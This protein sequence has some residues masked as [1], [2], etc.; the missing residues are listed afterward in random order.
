[1]TQNASARPK[2]TTNAE[3]CEELARRLK[4]N[5]SHPAKAIAKQHEKSKL[6]VPERL[7]L[8]FD[9]KSWR[10]EI[11]A[12][13]ADDM[14]E[15]HG[16][17]ITAAGCRVVI[18]LVHGRPTM[19]IANDSM[20]KAGAWFPMTIRKMLR[21]Q[22]IAIENRLPTVYLVDSA[23]V[24]LPLQEEIF[25]DKEHAGRIFYN[26]SRMSAMGI[27]QVALVCGPCVAGGA[28]L[29]VLSDEIIMVKGTSNMFLA[30][31]YLVEAAIGERVDAETLGGAAMHGQHSG[32]ADFEEDT[33]QLAI[34]RVREIA[35][36]WPRASAGLTREEPAAPKR[37]VEDA[38]T[39]L[40]AMRQMAYDM[41]KLL[42]CIVDEGSFAEFKRNYGRS[43]LCGIARIDGWAVGIVANQ[44]ELVRSGGGEIQIG[45]VI[46]SDSADKAARFILNCNQKGI[47]IIYLQ[48]V[49]G[50]MVGSRAERGGII[51]DGAKLVNAVSNSR[52]PQITM[53]VG[54]SNG[55]GNYALCGR[56]FG[57]RFV[58][59][60][61][62]ARVSVMGGEQAAKTL[63]SLEKQRRK[64]NPMTTEEEQAFLA[65][66]IE[67]YNDCSSPY[68]A[69]SRLWIDAVID[70]RETR[71]CISRLIA[72]CNEAPLA[73]TFNNGVMQT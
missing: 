69:A 20:V 32:T 7:T 22:E 33:E 18:G 4:A 40:P 41:R 11:G 55:A 51:K 23:G 58:L 39:I 31:P 56:A 27:P 28:Y 34:E 26:N 46:Y 53:I 61:P 73:P 65:R 13:A 62:S 3:L 48:D 43:L 68:H 49:T 35:R 38:L 14:Y 15:E 44:R 71:D 52:V 6:T 50:F 17:G 30:G 24:F 64:S 16:G 59:A 66:T 54:N 12:F 10:M 60:W 57:P 1:M 2:P 29:P 8:L 37:P 9:K 42:D 47:P 45:G 19:V 5:A 25:P 67:H 63:L 72:A 36:D 70:P 21:G